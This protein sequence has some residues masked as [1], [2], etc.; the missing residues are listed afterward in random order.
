MNYATAVHE[1]AA[2]LR[3]IRKQWAEL[4]LAIE[5]P[6][7]DVWPRGSSRTPCAPATTSSSSSR[8]GRRSCCVST[9]PR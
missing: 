4:L 5:T 7:V 9:L 1:T 2:A 6:P 8:T 3:S